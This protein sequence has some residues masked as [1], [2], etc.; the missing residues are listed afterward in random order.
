MTTHSGLSDS[1]IHVKNLREKMPW[2][3]TPALGALRETVQPDGLPYR[4]H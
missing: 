2:V 4:K 3:Y 1:Q